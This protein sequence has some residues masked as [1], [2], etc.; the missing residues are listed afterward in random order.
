MLLL[1]SCV[2]RNIKAVKVM[3]IHIEIL[4]VKIKTD[5]SKGSKHEHF[6]LGYCLFV[7]D[8]FS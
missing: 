1:T 6:H 8:V 2:E 4:S 7:V 3:L 5:Y